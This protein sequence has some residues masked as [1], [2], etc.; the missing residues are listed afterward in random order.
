M[1]E[2]L[3]AQGVDP[4]SGIPGSCVVP[5]LRR[6]LAAFGG[7]PAASFWAVCRAGARHLASTGCPAC[8]GG[9]GHVRS[10][11]HHARREPQA[12]A[13]PR[14][15]FGR[16]WLGPEGPGL[17][18]RALAGSA[19]RAPAARARAHLNFI[20]VDSCASERKCSTG[21]HHHRGAGGKLGFGSVST[22]RGRRGVEGAFREHRSAGRGREAPTKGVRGRC[23]GLLGA[24]APCGARRP[25]WGRIRGR[26][27][28]ELRG[29]GGG[30][31]A[32]LAPWLTR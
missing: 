13:A 3:S 4:R 20:G 27:L 11:S 32:S 7:R 12:C 26:F 18:A 21:Q 8:P 25:G 2:H 16:V 14:P 19:P 15:V 10:N 24:S 28:R 17:A 5:S 29:G 6:R 9:S 1:E 31:D 23:L 30:P 22:C